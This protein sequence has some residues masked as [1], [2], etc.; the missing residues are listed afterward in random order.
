MTLV[1]HNELR[2]GAI[3]QKTLATLFESHPYHEH[4]TTGLALN[5][6][7]ANSIVRGHGGT[8]TMKSSERGTS[9]EIVLPMSR[10][11]S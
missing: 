6:Q 2:D 8:I 11:A 3:S 9:V 1:I 10:L 4:S 7:I 5:L